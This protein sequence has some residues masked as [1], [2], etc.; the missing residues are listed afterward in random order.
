[1]TDEIEQLGEFISKK[2]ALCSN[3][4]KFSIKEIRTREKHLSEDEVA[5]RIDEAILICSGCGLIEPVDFTNQGG[6]F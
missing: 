2:Q 5:K 4:C 6:D 3:N 1:M